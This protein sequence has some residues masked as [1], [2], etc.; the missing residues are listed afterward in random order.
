KGAAVPEILKVVNE[1]FVSDNPVAPKSKIIL[2][3]AIILGF[4]VP[5]GLVYLKFL[6]DNKVHNRA[7]VEAYLDVPIVG[8][9]PK[10]EGMVSI[11]NVMSEVAEAFRILRTNM[12]FLLN[13]KKDAGS[14]VV[15]ITSTVAKEGKS[16]VANNL[17]K[18]LAISDKKVLLIGA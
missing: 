11:S 8:Q 9:I 6:L 12:A 4:L 13:G 15:F 5:F 10:S 14:L 2:L 7:D 1:A 3:A 16:F 18:I 17:S